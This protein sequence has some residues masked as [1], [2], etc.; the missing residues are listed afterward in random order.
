[1]MTR[2]TTKAL[3]AARISNIPNV[4]FRCRSCIFDDSEVLVD[5]DKSGSSADIEL[6][7]KIERV[8]I[9]VAA[10]DGLSGGKSCIKLVQ[11]R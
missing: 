6:G 9:A 2:A 10:S 4:G 3:N 1:M 8:A 11:T 5:F 7:S